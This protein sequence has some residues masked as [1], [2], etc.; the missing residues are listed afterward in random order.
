M[1]KPQ[2][3]DVNNPPTPTP[4]D[5][6]Q[7]SQCEQAFDEA[8]TKAREHGKWPARVSA[9]RDMLMRR[10]LEAVA[11]RYCTVGWAVDLHPIDGDTIALI[12][13]KT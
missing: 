13:R 8:I 6:A 4:F 1:L 5:L 10:N 7:Q 12:S 2:N 3:T 11:A 9:A